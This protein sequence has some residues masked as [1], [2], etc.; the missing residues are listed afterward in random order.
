[1]F[2]TDNSLHVFVGP[3]LGLAAADLIFQNDTTAATAIGA[4][5]IFIVDEA[6]AAFDGVISGDFKIGQKNADGT[7]AFTPLLDFANCTLKPKN[8]VTNRSEQSVVIGFDGSSGSIQALN[9]NR[10]TLRVAFKNNTDMFSEQSDLHFFEYVSDAAAQQIE[11]VDYLAKIMS[12]NEKF[13]GKLLGNKRGSVKVERLSAQASTAIGNSETVDLVNGS[14]FVLAKES[15]GTVSTAHGLVAGDYVRLGH[16]TDDAYGIYKVV[17]VDVGNIVIDQPYQGATEA[18]AAAGELDAVPTDDACGLKISALEQEWKLGRLTDTQVTFEVTLDGWG[19][20]AAPAVTAAVAGDGHG[21]KVA[22]LEWFGKGAQGAPYRTGIISNETDIT[23]YGNKD[24][25]YDMLEIDATLANPSHAVAGS[26][27]SKCKVV[28]A[29]P[30]LIHA[31]DGAELNASFGV[32]IY[33]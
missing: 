26:G 5:S 19:T 31:T 30:E 3:N 18:A 17:S 1:M 24:V 4:G 8:H 2:K 22:E 20:T 21:K 6:G 15:D 33:A 29:I 27:V 10:Y 12:K 13:S 9:S 32:T 7:F 25:Y 11:I 28:L 14:T 16:E 23:L